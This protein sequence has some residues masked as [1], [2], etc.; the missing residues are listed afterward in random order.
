VLDGMPHSK[1]VGYYD[2]TG[3]LTLWN[4]NDGLGQV[5][6]QAQGNFAGG[7]S[8]T[9]SIRE[10]ERLG[11]VIQYY[12]NDRLNGTVILGFRTSYSF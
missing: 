12:E 6:C 7:T 5:M 1:A 3:G 10:A 4:N 11:P 2:V 9:P 8:S